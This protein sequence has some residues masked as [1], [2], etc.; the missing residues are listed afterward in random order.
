MLDVLND[1]STFFDDDVKDAFGIDFGG[2][3][4]EYTAYDQY[5]YYA[6]FPIKTMSLEY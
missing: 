1:K 4:G 5:N 6:Y 2:S 3:L